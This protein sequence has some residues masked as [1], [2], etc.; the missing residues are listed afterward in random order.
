M[1]HL[2]NP[3]DRKQAGWPKLRWLDCVADNLANVDVM[4][5]RTFKDPR[6]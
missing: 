5:W 1:T 3:G 2:L 6:K 4:N